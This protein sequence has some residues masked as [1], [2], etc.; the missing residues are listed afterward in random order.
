MSAVST[1]PNNCVNVG[2][3]ALVC[4][5]NKAQWGG[6]TRASVPTRLL[7]IYWKIDSK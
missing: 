2:T 1:P 5:K 7:T 4:P 6:Q 3:D